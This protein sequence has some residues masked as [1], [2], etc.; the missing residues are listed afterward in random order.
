MIDSVD[1]A[2]K[3]SI[4]GKLFS[5]ANVKAK[6]VVDMADAGM[7]WQMSVGVRPGKI[8]EF[9]RG[10]KVTVNGQNF[11]GPLTV[12]RNNRIRETSFTALGAATDTNAQIFSI[13][14]KSP[15]NFTGDTEMNQA[16]HDAA[17]AE[18]NAKIVAAEKR[19][20]DA[21]AKNTAT[22]ARLTA[23]ED[24]N[25]AKEKTERET[26]VKA[27]FKTIALEYKDDVAKPYLEMSADAFAAVSAQM[28][29]RPNLDTKLTGEQTTEGGA[30]IDV[31]DHLELGTKAREYMAEM[32]AKGVDVPADKAVAHVKKLFT[33]KA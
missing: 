27:L 28:T 1:L 33:A 24:A 22:E 29:K 18:L 11:T 12:F 31:N 17:V 4:A 2:N 13:G 3:I 14:G 6:E 10:E 15:A 25:K 20:T 21:E 26:A 5:A 9:G 16:D 19:A 23:I 32:K 8:E 30:A 7:P